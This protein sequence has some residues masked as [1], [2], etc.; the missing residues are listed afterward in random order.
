MPSLD[1]FVTANR[2]ELIRRCRAKV[3]SRTVPAPTEAE[4]DHGVP[5]FLGQLVEA[6]RDGRSGSNSA[7]GRGAVQHGHDLLLKGFTFSQVVHDYGDVCQAITD[8]AVERAAAR[9]NA[10]VG[11]YDLGVDHP[12]VGEKFLLDFHSTHCDS[13]P[14]GMRSNSTVSAPRLGVA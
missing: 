2:D 3:A 11:H 13:L 4:I 12:G 9:E 8:L 10:D 7:I 1:Q 5:L 14:V 6:L